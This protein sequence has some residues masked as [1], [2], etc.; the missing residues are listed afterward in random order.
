MQPPDTRTSSRSFR[1]HTQ[2]KGLE[3]DEKGGHVTVLLRGKWK[4]FVYSK[5]FRPPPLKRGSNIEGYSSHRSLN[6]LIF[7][8]FSS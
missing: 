7:A 4:R 6:E 5:A 2:T 3:G 8:F 1:D